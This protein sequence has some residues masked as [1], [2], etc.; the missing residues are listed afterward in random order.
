[1][2]FDGEPHFEAFSQWCGHKYTRVRGGAEFK[3]DPDTKQF[4]TAIL[5]HIQFIKNNIY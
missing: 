4:N 3:V 5:S 2:G 1:M